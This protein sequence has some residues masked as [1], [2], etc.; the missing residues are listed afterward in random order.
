MSPL[1]PARVSTPGVSGVHRTHRGAGRPC[2]IPSSRRR[3][4]VSIKSWFGGGSKQD[5]KPGQKPGKKEE[6]YTIDDLIVLERYDEAV[7]HLKSRI[8]LN[9]NDL[10]MHLKLAEAYIGLKQHDRAV[11]EFG[12]VAEEYAQDGF[13]E[14]GIALLSKAQ[15]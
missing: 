2:T 3:R 1:R 6:E 14:K 7:E 12:Y 10:H 4:A 8:K 5:Q 9:P 15:K 13:Y 11:D